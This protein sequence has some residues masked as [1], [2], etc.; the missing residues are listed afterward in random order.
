MLS[1][2]LCIF[3]T[4]KGGGR[5]GKFSAGVSRRVEKTDANADEYPVVGM[6]Q[7]LAI[8]LTACPLTQ[9]FDI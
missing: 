1:K 9:Q 8:L 7:T 3:P 2:E 5:V 4:G 6:T